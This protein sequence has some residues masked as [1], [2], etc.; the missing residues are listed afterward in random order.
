[1]TGDPA[2]TPPLIPFR[3]RVDF[4]QTPW[5]ESSTEPPSARL[6]ETSRLQLCSGA[7]SEVS[8]LEANMEPKVFR[9]GGRYDG[10]IQRPGQVTYATVI[11]KRGMTAHK[12][13]W[14]W[15][16]LVAEG[17]TANRLQ[18]VLVHLDMDVKE[19]NG[20]RSFE[21]VE[22]LR[23]IM[24]NALPTKFK[25]ATY[26]G[27]GGEVGVEELHFVHEGLILEGGS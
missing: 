15:F 8:G 16:R 26:S 22:R 2:T 1:M 14:Q 7:F 27:A 17:K 11:L 21:P 20:T 4:Y 23:W 12:H 9:Q 18:A 6:P 13:L 25:A 10:E 5:D 3:F 19:V 24:K